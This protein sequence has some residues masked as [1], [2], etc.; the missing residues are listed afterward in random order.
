MYLIFDT[1]TTGLPNNWK[2]PHTDLE[3]WPRL[4]QLAYQLHDNKGNLIKARNVIVTPDGFTIPFNAEKI[5]G[6]STKRAQEEGI[7]LEE[8]IQEFAE[9]IKQT[10]VLI[11]HNILGY[12]I[13][14]MG[15][16]FIRAGVDE[17]LFMELD[18]FDTMKNTT[19][20]TA[21][22]GG[23]GGRF[24]PPKLEE[25]HE[26]LF[27]YKFQDAHDAAYDV[28]ANSKCYF[29][30]L[31]VGVAKPWDDT[32]VKA[33]IYEPPKLDDANFKKAQEEKKKQ[34]AELKARQGKKLDK[35]IPFSHLHVHSEFSIL[36]ST[37]KVKKILEK[38]RELKMEAVAITDMGNLHGAFNAVA[39]QGDDLKVI[40]GCEFYVA[41]ERKKTQF[42]KDNP[43]KRFTQLLLAKHQEG[44]KNL[45]K[46]SSIGYMEGFYS[47]VP[48]IDKALIEKYKDGLIATT[49]NLNGEI[50]NLILNIGEHQAEEAF[51]WWLELFKDDF[52]VEL[53]R[54]GLP[55]EERV[56]EVLL[57]FA[58]KYKVKIIASNDVYYI[59]QKDAPAHD[60]LWCVKEGKTMSME[61]GNGRRFR[62]ALPNDK[63][64]FKSQEEMNQLFFDLPEA[65]EN[66]QEIVDKC[67]PLKL[68]RDILLPEFPMPPEFTTQDDYLKYL[69]FEGAKKRYGDPLEESVK[70]RLEYEL[71]IIKTM[72]FP[73]YFLIVQDFI[74]A[75][76]DMGVAVGPGRGS[77][78][79]SAV[80]FCIGITN[81]DPIKYNLLFERFLNP[82]R[83]S[84]PD[85]DIDFDDRG[86]QDVIDWVVKKYGKN[87]VAQIITYG[88]MAAKM[89]IKDVARAEELPLA[90]ANA[91]AKLVPDAPGTS[92]NKAF[93]EVSSLREIK[94]KDQGLQGKVL[95]LA[96]TVEGSVRGTGIHAAGVIIAPDDLLEYIPVCT[97]KD[98]DLLVT[99]FDGRVVESAGML[100]MDFLGLKTLTIIKDAL[101]L[102]KKNHG[103][104]IDIDEIPLDDPKTF[105][106]YQAGKTVGTFQF[107]SPGMQKYLKELKPT[108]IEDLIAMNALYRPGPMQFIPNFIN[109][110]HGKEE[111]EYPHELLEP[112]LNY[113]NGI[114]VYQEQIMQTA[115]ILAGYSLGGADILRRAMGKKKIEEMDKQRV[116]FVEGAKEKNNIPKQTAEEIFKVMEKFASYGFNRSHSAAYSVVAYQT[117]YLKANYPAEYMAAVMSNSMGTIDKISFFME[118]CKSSG[119]KVLG[120][121]VNESSRDFDVNDEGA[122][123]FGMG[124]IKGSG[125]AAVDAII[126]ERNKNGQFKDVWEFVERMDLRKVNKK[127]FE[128][129]AYA[130]AF[131]SL[132]EMHRAQY[133]YIE[134]GEQN[135]GIEKLLKHGNAI[136]AE[137]MSAQASL[138]G[139][140]SGMEMPRPR[141]ASCEPWS[142]LVKLRHEKEVVGFYITGHPLDM[143]KME[144]ENFCVPLARIENHRN[145]EIAVGGSITSV[146]IREGR[147][148]NQF[149]LFTVEDYETS[150][151]LALF[152]QAFL[153]NRN[154]L[155]V[156][157]FVYIK[158]KVQ[159]RYNQPGQWE[160][161]PKSISLLSDV[162]DKLC[163]QIK[164]RIDIAKLD[165]RLATELE[166]LAINH[167]GK[168][169]MKVEVYSRED[170]IKL[171]LLSRKYKVDPSTNLIND[172]RQLDIDECS[173][174]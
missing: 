130:G 104:D 134:S 85:I 105:E 101:R 72:G 62:Y 15:A 108:N 65:L 88:T 120:P 160:L 93:E 69:T 26:K 77:A 94:E 173:V 116:I 16:E 64:Y 152:G 143:F 76:R 7:P 45:S 63:Y 12:D 75:A 146:N 28:A 86:R 53:M 43:D 163:K 6:I 22:Q 73:G 2:A 81:I 128:S 99:Q 33:I 133:F 58:K 19:E 79:G 52:Y 153:E 14:L 131:D 59:N 126:D 121:D 92:L 162:K 97:S 107:E 35:V 144:M 20:F 27:G 141:L 125:D 136:Q 87:Q 25:L 1:E 111:I 70:E 36:Q 74:Q 123:R 34:E 119:I 10:K 56:N 8:V 170:N 129:L 68:K 47:G 91:L 3:N 124:A 89:S 171:D 115:Q 82:E 148:G 84:M 165:M 112:I 37:A 23:R 137:K 32:P 117:G 95:N 67:S 83:V 30:L 9:D 46:L 142:D 39:G 118:E 157:Q 151:N 167:T 155:N 18:T 169:D 5:H 150:V 48:R 31:K 174:S 122:I 145:Q 149:A 61:V 54:H 159:E 42:T 21:L 29:E 96:H 166:E 113:S 80:A 50:P 161:S 41:V 11:G 132:G 78:A 172:I 13:P 103:V 55:E 135:S 98:A 17:S 147:R 139:A 40:I 138:F 51:Q 158:G 49:G 114:M 140:G 106:L 154:M 4:V 44:Y 60:V 168:C 156:G 90:E 24:K 57:S 38:A 110:K 66:V 100:K 102:I 164:L 109:R 127:T 71:D